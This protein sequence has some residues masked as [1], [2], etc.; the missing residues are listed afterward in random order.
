MVFKKWMCRG[1]DCDPKNCK[2]LVWW[3]HVKWTTAN[4][5]NQILIATCPARAESHII[6]RDK[7]PD[8]WIDMAFVLKRNASKWDIA[9]H[10]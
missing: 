5:L 3:I 6:W 10:L 9:K 7:D 1:P 2:G 8:N 4:D